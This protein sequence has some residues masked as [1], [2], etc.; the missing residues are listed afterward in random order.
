MV[1]LLSG[2]GGRHTLPKA[3]SQA[4]DHRLTSTSSGTTS[5]TGAVAVIGYCLG[6]GLALLLAPDRGFTVSSVNYGTAAKDVYT[7]DLLGRARAIVAT[8]GGKDR[9]LRG[10]ADRLQAALSA[11]GVEHN[12]KEYP[13]A[14]HGFLNDHDAA[15]DN[16]PVLF[17]VVGKLMPGAGYHEASAHDARR[18]IVAFFDAH[19]KG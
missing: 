18:R 13:D 17:R 4:G 14:G 5:C 8:Y 15:R 3:R 12:V 10:A 16:T 19:L 2:L 6:G 1:L 9:T 7:A 11:A